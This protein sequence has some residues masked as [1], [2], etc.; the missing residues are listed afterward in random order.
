M[1][2]TCHNLCYWASLVVVIQLL[3][4][5][6]WLIKIPIILARVDYSIDGASKSVAI[7]RYKKLIYD[8]D[9]PFIW[10]AHPLL[11]YHNEESGVEGSFAYLRV[12]LDGNI[13]DVGFYI[14]GISETRYFMEGEKYHLSPIDSLYSYVDLYKLFTVNKEPHK[15]YV[16]FIFWCPGFEPSRY[17]VN[18]EASWCS[19]SLPGGDTVLRVTFELNA[20]NK[21]TK[22]PK[23][24][25]GCIDLTKSVDLGRRDDIFVKQG[26]E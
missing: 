2:R 25:K 23:A 20:I 4:S 18:N 26:D 9:D 12:G 17:I 16:S 19:F 24:V 22:E 6:T 5:C 11:S 3:C 1:K 14:E 8:G 15:D 7:Y 13:G 21:D 10:L